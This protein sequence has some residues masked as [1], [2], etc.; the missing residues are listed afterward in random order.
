TRR[1]RPDR[2]RPRL[3]A[4]SRRHR[5][6]AQG[7]R[8]PFRALPRLAQNEELG[9]T[10]REA[11]SRGGLVKGVPEMSVAPP[12]GQDRIMI[13]GPKSDGTYIIEFHMADGGRWRSAGRLER[14]A[15][16]TLSRLSCLTASSSRM[17]PI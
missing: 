10:G 3:Q 9:C 5:L 1:R 6:E 15:Y 17:F 7:F 16:S 14:P 4:W 13:Y 11:G 12:G 8:L 2:L